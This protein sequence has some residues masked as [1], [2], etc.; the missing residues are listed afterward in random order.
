[1][2]NT[3]GDTRIIVSSSYITLQGIGLRR[4]QESNNEAPSY[5]SSPTRLGIDIFLVELNGKEDNIRLA[6]RTG[7]KIDTKR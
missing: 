2:V 5:S 7:R 3:R 4:R 1:M 6:T